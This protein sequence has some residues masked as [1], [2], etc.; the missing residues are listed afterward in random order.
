M[1]SGSLNCPNCG[2]PLNYA[3]NAA[4]VVCEHCGS[5]VAVRSMKPPSIPAVPNAVSDYGQAPAGSPALSG[6]ASLAMG[7]ADAAR[8]IQLLRDN[9][10]QAAIQFYQTKTGAGFD[11][12]VDAV[13]AIR[14]GL[15][16]APTAG[17]FPPAPTPPFT[18]LPS[19]M[20]Y[21][22]TP[23]ANRP[24]RSGACSCSALLLGI[25]ALFMCLF[26]GC[27]AY[28]QTKSVFQCSLHQAETTLA[29]REILT[30]PVYGGYL[31]LVGG[32]HESASLTSSSLTADFWTPVWGGNGWGMLGGHISQNNGRGGIV[33]A[34]LYKDGKTIPVLAGAFV[35]C[36][37]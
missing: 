33:T 16:D 20:V 25:V 23:A 9:Q 19:P 7:P 13:R 36:S 6:L 3:E 17:V 21:A 29:Q 32:Y 12:A 27:G 10:E 24:T 18:S 35:D 8:V 14:D 1:S 4:T 37:Q 15:R 30:P 26:A 2:A 11:D 28:L 22:P 34:T 5:V 31:V